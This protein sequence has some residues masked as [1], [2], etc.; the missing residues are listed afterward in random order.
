MLQVGIYIPEQDAAWE[1]EPHA[2][3]ELLEPYNHCDMDTCLCP[4]G[5]K[6]NRDDSK[7]E[8]VVCHW[9]GS[10]GSH[11]GCISTKTTSTSTSSSSSR[12]IRWSCQSCA[13]IDDELR[14]ERKKK[15]PSCSPVNQDSADMP[16][17]KSLMPSEHVGRKLPVKRSNTLQSPSMT[18]EQNDG[19]SS[20]CSPPALTHDQSVSTKTRRSRKQKRNLWKRGLLLRSTAKKRKVTSAT[21]TQAEASLTQSKTCQEEQIPSQQINAEN[22]NPVTAETPI[23]ISS[24]LGSEA[25]CCSSQITEHKHKRRKR[26][27]SLRKLLMES[28]ILSDIKNNKLCDSTTSQ[29]APRLRRQTKTSNAPYVLRDRKLSR[30][31]LSPLPRFPNRRTLRSDKTLK[32]IDFTSS[33]KR[34]L[35]EPSLKSTPPQKKQ[36]LQDGNNNNNNNNNNDDINNNN[37]T[38]N[39]NET[40]LNSVNHSESKLP[41]T[42]SSSPSSCSVEISRESRSTSCVSPVFSKCLAKNTICLDKE[43]SE[44]IEKMVDCDCISC[45]DYVIISSDNESEVM[46]ENGTSVI[47]SVSLCETD[48]DDSGSLTVMSV[49]MSEAEANNIP[50]VSHLQEQKCDDPNCDCLSSHSWVY[51]SQMISSA[52]NNVQFA[53]STSAYEIDDS[54]QLAAMKDFIESTPGSAS[55]SSSSSSVITLTSSS[56]YESCKSSNELNANSCSFEVQTII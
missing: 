32:G 41:L 14:K 24:S 54:F 22:V 29:S 31:S 27:T 38:S 19:E 44:V 7:W 49:S 39:V 11:I 46:D 35:Q 48:T 13:L 15:K 26:C 3:Q 55:P 5:R 1:M 45:C 21:M 9:C 33:Y 34:T 43:N 25:A 36:K 4:R 42:C 50:A 10:Q 30:T 56:D 20:T 52:N 12:R 37:N 23:S 2:Y 17:S 8:I 28:E 47:M 40:C 16:S 51:S 18:T 6:Y 53:S